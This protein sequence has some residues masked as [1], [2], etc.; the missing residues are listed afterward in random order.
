MTSSTVV[1]IA[2]GQILV[3]P[4]L[5]EANM[6]RAVAAID[7]AA[8]AGADMLVLPECLD[9]GW[10]HDSARGGAEP[11]PGPR[12]AMLAAR[13]GTAGMV[14]AAGLSERDGDHVYNTAILV[15]RDGSVLGKH[16]KVNELD[17]ARSLY[18]T[19][20]K[21]EVFDT[22][23]GPIGLAICADLLAPEIGAGLCRMGAQLIL[24]PS[25]WAVPE[26]HDETQSPYGDEWRSAYG[27]IA[28]QF[29][30]A[31]ASAS[32]VGRVEGGAWHG[33]PVIGRSLAMAGDGS[34]AA[35]GRYGVEDMPIATITLTP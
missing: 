34:V 5:P 4:G 3:E 2:L 21:L 31:V 20:R 16:R 26:T 11:I 6:A 35:M 19:G 24:S 14:L 18:R 7:C 15:E 23:F 1:R 29:K 33:R 10:A 25:A 13:A 9:F 12:A 17:F 28:A 27:D 8:Q 30:V 22:S 32:N